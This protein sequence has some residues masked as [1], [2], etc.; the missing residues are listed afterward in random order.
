MNVCM[1]VCTVCTVCM[2]VC[3]YV[4]MY[5]CMYCITVCMH[6]CVYVCTCVLI[7]ARKAVS[8]GS[9]GVLCNDPQEV[10]H[11]NTPDSSHYDSSSS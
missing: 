11:L 10:V 8:Q 2:Y 4:R 1:Y 9:P 7:W 6:V 3:M 5:V